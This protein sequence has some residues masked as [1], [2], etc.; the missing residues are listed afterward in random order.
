MCFDEEADED[1]D[2]RFF[3]HGIRELGS[4]LGLVVKGEER[5]LGIDEET[6]LGLYEA[7]GLGLYDEQ[8]LAD[9]DPPVMFMH[10]TGLHP[11]R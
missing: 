2:E 5:G 10:S 7:M 11:L 6:G 1:D 4:V 8:G 3:S 9:I